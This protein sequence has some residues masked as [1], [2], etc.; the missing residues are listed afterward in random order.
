M[1]RFL[2]PMLTVGLATGALWWVA[3]APARAD[4]VATMPATPLTGTVENV[5]GI[6]PLD[7]T[8]GPQGIANNFQGM[9]AVSGTLVHFYTPPNTGGLYYTNIPGDSEIT[10]GRL[11]GILNTTF[12]GSTVTG[13]SMS[14]QTNLF[15]GSGWTSTTLT[16]LGF[17]GSGTATN[18]TIN[19]PA[20]FG[21][22]T[23]LSVQATNG[24]RLNEVDFTAHL[25]GAI[26]IFSGF[27]IADA[28]P[29]P[30]PSSLVLAGVG[31]A[32]SI[33]LFRPGRH[34]RRSGGRPPAA[35]PGGEQEARGARAQEG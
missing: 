5:T 12:P 26:R 28:A 8:Q 13:F 32:G 31:L 4:F 27:Q 24:W 10:N 35:P 16:M 7:S 17:D 1:A 29:V 19:L 9:T 21:T 34:G 18:E 11:G 6:L 14:L 23:S 30:E 2:T 15:G 20:P 3:A 25:D 22:T 33:V